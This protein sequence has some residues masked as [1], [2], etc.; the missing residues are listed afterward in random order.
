MVTGWKQIN[1]KWYYFETSGVMATS[2]WINGT[3]YVKSSGVMAV[4]EWVDGGKYYVDAKGKYV[5]G[6]KK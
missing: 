3:Y 4:N 1:N 5:P 6:K 2:K